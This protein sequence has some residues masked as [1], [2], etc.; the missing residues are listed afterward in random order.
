MTIENDRRNLKLA[1]HIITPDLGPYT[2][3]DFGAASTIADLGYKGAE[4]QAGH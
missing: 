4:K 1:D 2:L 3:L